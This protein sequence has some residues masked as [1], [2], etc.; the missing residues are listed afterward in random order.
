VV[1]LKD[2]SGE[3]LPTDSL[4]INLIS[5]VARHQFEVVPLVAD[6]PQQ[7]VDSEARAKQ[8]DYILFTTVSQVK[9]PGSGGLSS[10]SLPKGVA[11]DAAKFQ[12]LTEVT[13]YKVGKPLPELKDLGVAAAADQFG[14]NAVMATFEKGADRVAQQVQEDAHPTAASKTQKTPAKQSATRAKPK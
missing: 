14:V 10:A 6:V 12:A 5:E 2:V 9:A 8:C 7:E 13:L 1:K 11:L 4:Q 3:S